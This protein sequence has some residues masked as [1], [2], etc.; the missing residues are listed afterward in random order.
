MK[1]LSVRNPFHVP[2]KN[3]D[4]AD[5][6]GYLNALQRRAIAA[7]GI[8]PARHELCSSRRASFI[9]GTAVLTGCIENSESIWAQ[10][11]CWHWLLEDAALFDKPVENVKGRLGLWDYNVE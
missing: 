6:S 11:G 8:V 4:P 10:K 2:S 5:L 1:T 7:K 9:I 3:D